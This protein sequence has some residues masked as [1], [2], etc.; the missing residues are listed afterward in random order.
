[1][2]SGLIGVL[3]L[4]RIDTV[5]FFQKTVVEVGFSELKSPKK[6][7]FSLSWRKTLLPNGRILSEEAFQPTDYETII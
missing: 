6:D 5:W 1:M 3:F 2:I 4:V 7:V